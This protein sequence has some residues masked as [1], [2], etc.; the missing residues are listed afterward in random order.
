MAETYKQKSGIYP[1]LPI[2]EEDNRDPNG[3]NKHLR[4]RQMIHIY[5][6][7]LYFL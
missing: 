6:I 5:H 4:V 1:T 2:D 3:I 7:L